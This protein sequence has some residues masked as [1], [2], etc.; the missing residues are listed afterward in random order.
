MAGLAINPRYAPL[1]QPW[2]SITTDEHHHPTN[3][4]ISLDSFK[5][6]LRAPSVDGVMSK[7]GHEDVPED[8]RPA[9]RTRPAH[10]DRISQLS[11]ELLL[12]ILSFVSVPTLTTCQRYATT[13]SV[14]SIQTNILQRLS[15][16]LYNRR[17]F[18]V[19]EG[20]ILQQICSSPRVEITGHQGCRCPSGPSVLFVKTVQ[21]VR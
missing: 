12:R 8:E 11:D 5:R 6:R 15:E 18:A 20:G 4:H 7:R 13:I 9:K 16:V 14:S 2:Q 10:V 19:M 21:V 17:R 3:P 1:G